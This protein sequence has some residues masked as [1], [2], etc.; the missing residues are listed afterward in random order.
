MFSFC[1]Y[2]V[3][4]VVCIKKYEIYSSSP[5]WKTRNHKV[6]I[7]PRMK[8]ICIDAH[9]KN[10]RTVTPKQI[11]FN[12]TENTYTETRHINATCVTIKLPVNKYRCT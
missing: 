3:F 2:L 1:T 7:S 10:L 11:I 12:V 8:A 9:L 5:I 6:F 4:I